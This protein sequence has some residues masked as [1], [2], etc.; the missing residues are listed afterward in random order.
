M[1]HQATKPERIVKL[2]N[3][4]KE[5]SEKNFKT[6]VSTKKWNSRVEFHGMSSKLTIYF[7]WIEFHELFDGKPCQSLSVKKP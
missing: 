1:E 4:T 6:N 3:Y 5:L 7:S 2:T